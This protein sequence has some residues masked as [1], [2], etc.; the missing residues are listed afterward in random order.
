MTIDYFEQFKVY[1]EE[2][3][4]CFL[5]LDFENENDFLENIV[6]FIFSEQNLFMYY[7]DLIEYDSKPTAR[8]Y[9]ILYNNIS[10]FLDR[11]IK[12]LVNDKNYENYELLINDFIATSKYIFKKDKV[13]KIGEHILH[14][15]LK[16]YFN[17]KCVIPKFQLITSENMS[18]NGVDALFFK[19]ETNEFL[20]G[21]S[22]FVNNLDAGISKANESLAKYPDIIRK[23]YENLIKQGIS[24]QQF[25]LNKVFT[26]L[27]SEKINTNDKFVDFMNSSNSN[28]VISVLITHGKENNLYKI[29]NDLVRINKIKIDHNINTRYIIMSLPIL[30]KKKFLEVALKV[31]SRKYEEYRNKKH[32]T[33]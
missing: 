4:F 11:E 29:I 10:L 19:K 7:E 26:Q 3:R 27:Y 22:K 5:H 32:T 1:N 21:E 28:M 30:N 20:F 16:K 12:E 24:L 13:G 31:T 8:N 2:D 25:N 18:A 9:E 6:E 14:I 15:I 17:Y 23:E 33:N